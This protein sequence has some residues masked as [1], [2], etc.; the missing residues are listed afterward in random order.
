MIHHTVPSFWERYYKL[1]DD[2]KEQADKN[3][4]LLKENPAHPSLH[5]KK[6]GNYY[7]VRINIR[8]RALGIFLKC[9]KF[10]V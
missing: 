6:I 4:T 3:Y 10:L 9:Q 1:P 7:S 2:V 5:F 8:Y